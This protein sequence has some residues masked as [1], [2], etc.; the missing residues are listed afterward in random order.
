LY[1]KNSEIL[2][3]SYKKGPENLIKYFGTA[4]VSNRFL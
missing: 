4:G 3:K 2:V 1:P